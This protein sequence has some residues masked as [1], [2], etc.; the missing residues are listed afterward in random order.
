MATDFLDEYSVDDLKQALTD[1]AAE[2]ACEYVALQ[3]A[4]RSHQPITDADKLLLGTQR[5]DLTTVDLTMWRI[6][7]WEGVQDRLWNWYRTKS[8]QATGS[9]G[10]GGSSL[11]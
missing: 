4:K 3:V 11:G 1:T 5:S 9:N 6:A 10:Q 7:F 2:L 8:G